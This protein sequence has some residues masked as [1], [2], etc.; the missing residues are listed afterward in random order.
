MIHFGV[1]IWPK[2]MISVT[3]SKKC[4]IIKLMSSIIEFLAS[5]SKLQSEEIE[6]VTKRERANCLPECFKMILKS[7]SVKTCLFLSFKFP[8]W[9]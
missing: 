1:Y 3:P 6:R 9:V 4:C 7:E 5:I 2:S 8:F